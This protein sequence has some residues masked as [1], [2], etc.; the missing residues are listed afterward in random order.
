MHDIEDNQEIV[1]KRKNRADISPFKLYD[2]WLI[3]SF[4][5]LIILWIFYKEYY[6][7]WLLSGL[8]YSFMISIIIERFLVKISLI[9]YAVIRRYLVQIIV[10]TIIMS[11]TIGKSIGIRVYKNIDIK[12]IS[13]MSMDTALTINDSNRIKLL[14]FLGNKV[15]VSSLDN[16]RIIVLNQDKYDRIELT[17]NPVL[18]SVKTEIGVGN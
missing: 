4:F 18:D 16:E 11:F 6:L 2:F 13:A 8:F 1:A 17:T 12:Y 7:F 15:I 10:M 3:I 5:A 14:G 9:K